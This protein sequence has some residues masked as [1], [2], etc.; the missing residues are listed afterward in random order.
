MFP[1]FCDLGDDYLWADEGDTAVLAKSILQFG[2]PKAWDGVTFTDSDMGTREN[3]NL[4]MVSHPW[5]QYYVTAASFCLFG[6]TTF[7]ARFPFALAG[8]LTIP[9]VYMLIFKLTKDRKAAIAA[10]ILL[11]VSVQFLLFAR[12]CRNYSLSMFLTCLM[13]LQF[14]ELKSF[15]RALLFAVTGILSFHCHPSGLAPLVALALLTLIYK[16]FAPYRRWLWLS[17]PVIGIF[18]L[19]W[20]ALAK[21][22]YSENTTILQEWRLLIPRLLQFFIEWGSVTP[23]VAV[24]FLFCWLWVRRW[25]SEPFSWKTGRKI[26]LEIL[27]GGE[28]DLTILVLSVLAAY[29]ALIAL[30][31]SRTELWHVGLRHTT[32]IIPLTM[33]ITALLISK[34]SRNRMVLF[35]GLLAILSFTK[36]GRLTPWVFQY[37]ARVN[38][39]PSDIVAAHVP[40]SWQDKLFRTALPAFSRELWHHNRGAVARV[41]EFL[42]TNAAPGEVLITNYEWEPVYFHTGLPQ[43]LKI[44]PSYPIYEKVER[45]NFPYY[46]YSVRNARWLVWRSPWRGYRDYDLQGIYTALVEGGATLTHVSSIPETGWE[47]QPNV[48]FRRYPGKDYKFQFYENMKDVEI[49]RVDWPWTKASSPL[50]KSTPQMA[51]KPV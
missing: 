31:I 44:L 17:I 16:P 30:T 38:F 45:Y 34:V 46:V 9:L 24:I 49:F 20:F 19:P 11:I 35:L 13:L 4:V 39:D 28:R 14:F 33:V 21:T 1:L 29:G 47:N 12:Q 5:L 2:V 22:G 25:R 32:A 8:L 37:E 41:C 27:T 26:S 6:E 50:Q 42:K 7:A 15:R 10:C 36:V 48:H 43:G 3:E 51:E 40:K 18:T 23:V